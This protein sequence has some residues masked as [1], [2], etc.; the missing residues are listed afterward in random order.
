MHVYAARVAKEDKRFDL[1]MPK[2][3]KAGDTVTSGRGGNYRVA[4]VY[5]DGL[6]KQIAILVREGAKPRGRPPGS[7]TRK[8][9][10]S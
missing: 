9:R 1:E 3:L 7:K 10:A 8:K 6:K 2:P 4:Y 5:K